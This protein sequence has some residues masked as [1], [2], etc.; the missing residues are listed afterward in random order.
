MATWSC[1]LPAAPSAPG[2]GADHKRISLPLSPT[3]ESVVRSA[4]QLEDIFESLLSFDDGSNDEDDNMLPDPIQFVPNEDGHLL[5]C[6]RPKIYRDGCPS[7]TILGIEENASVYRE[8]IPSEQPAG[9]TVALFEV[10]S[11]ARDDAGTS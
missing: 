8:H 5:K 6:R 4:Q 11:A 10:A 3:T 7:A 2:E 1:C 9:V